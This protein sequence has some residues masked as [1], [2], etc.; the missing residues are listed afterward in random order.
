MRIGVDSE[1]ERGSAVVNLLAVQV[2]RANPAM[3]HGGAVGGEHAV[4]GRDVG[5]RDV[6]LGSGCVLGQEIG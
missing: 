2:N 1:A 6:C 5:G 4:K 3:C